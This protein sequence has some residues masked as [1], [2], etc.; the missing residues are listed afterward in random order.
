MSSYLAGIAMYQTGRWDV[1][2]YG[3][4]I[5][6]A[7]WCILFVNLKFK[8]LDK[9][10]LNREL[11]IPQAFLCYEH[12]QKHPFIGDYEKQFLNNKTAE[13]LEAERSNLPP[14]PWRAI[15]TNIPVLTL[16]VSAVSSVNLT[17]L[18]FDKKTI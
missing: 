11:F 8:S 9:H 17:F 10:V 2:F 5:V 15:L 4:G 12:P 6:T 3:S 14:T 7:I 18:S 13:Y 1:V 16:I